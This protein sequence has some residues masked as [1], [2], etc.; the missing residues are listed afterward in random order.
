MHNAALGG[1]VVATLDPVVP[2]PRGRAV[3]SSRDRARDGRASDD[4]HVEVIDRHDGA[5]CATGTATSERRISAPSLEKFSGG[6]GP[7]R[8]VPATLEPFAR[9]AGILIASTV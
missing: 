5:I 4:L 6:T 9:G 8:A 1:E 2:K 7:S 3:G